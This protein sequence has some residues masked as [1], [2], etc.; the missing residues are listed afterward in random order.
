MPFRWVTAD[1]VYGVGT[2]EMAFRRPG[3]GYVLGVNKNGQFNSWGKTPV[4]AG[5]AEEI[6]RGLDAAHWQ[7]LSA[8]NR[9]QGSRLHDWA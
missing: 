7:R 5:T 1:N 3:K 4:F 8:G 2:L 9:T 6:A